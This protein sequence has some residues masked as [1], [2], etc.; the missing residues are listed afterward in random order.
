[1]LGDLRTVAASAAPPASSKQEGAKMA[2]KKKAKQ[3]TQ[4]DVFKNGIEG[5]MAGYQA[6]ISTMVETA[7]SMKDG[8]FTAAYVVKAILGAMMIEQQEAAKKVAAE[9]AKFLAKAKAAG[10]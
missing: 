4:L 2:G 9:K 1:M 10:K 5:Y 6:A 7:H 8:N 3:P